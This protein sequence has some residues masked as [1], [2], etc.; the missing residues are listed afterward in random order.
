MRDRSGMESP[1]KGGEARFPARRLDSNR[2]V[3]EDPR[4]VDPAPE[5]VVEIDL[6][7]RRLDEDLAAR[8]GE[9]AVEEERHLAMAGGARPYRDEA[10]L[11]VREHTLAGR[12]GASPSTP[13]TDSTS[14]SQNRCSTLAVTF[15]AEP[16]SSPAGAS[17]PL[18]LPTPVP[19]S[20]TVTVS[21]AKGT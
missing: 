7:D 16:F 5:A 12:S 2:E 14:P 18:P 9:D 1:A 11:A 19:T 4:E 15:A 13:R 17:I 10:G 21:R 8:A 6:D 3:A 20:F